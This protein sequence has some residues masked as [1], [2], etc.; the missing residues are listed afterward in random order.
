MG[1]PAVALVGMLLSTGLQVAGS[2]QQANAQT[3]Q[4]KHQRKMA[5]RNAEIAELQAAD[6]EVRGREQESMLRARVNKLRGAQRAAIAGSG[7]TLDSPFA[8][9]LDESLFFESELDA[10]AI[11]RNTER[12]AQGF[13]SQAGL[14]R[15]QADLFQSA[16]QDARTSTILTGTAQVADQWLAFHDQG[17][18]EDIF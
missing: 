1:A 17:G 14:D 8:E 13:R 9:S 15:L 12:E 2:V 7:V 6:A 5:E 18:F 3:R 16:G 11:R 4:A 10:A